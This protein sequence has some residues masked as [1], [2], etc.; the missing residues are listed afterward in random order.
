MNEELLD[1]YDS[2]MNLLGISSKQQA[3]QEGL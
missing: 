3:H 1:I 2:D